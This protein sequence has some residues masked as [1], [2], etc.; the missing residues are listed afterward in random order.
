MEHYCT[1][2]AKAGLIVPID[3]RIH[4]VSADIDKL[5]VRVTSN[6]QEWERLD[7]KAWNFLDV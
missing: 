4:Q 2:L 3:E 1:T 6:Y 5:N 7:V